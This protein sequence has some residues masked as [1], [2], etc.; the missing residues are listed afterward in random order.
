MLHKSNLI[1]FDDMYLL[2]D[3]DRYDSPVWEIL[4]LFCMTLTLK[5]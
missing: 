5:N 4:V 1:D 3:N 2:L